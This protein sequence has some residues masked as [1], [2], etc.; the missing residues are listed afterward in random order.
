MRKHY[1]IVHLTNTPSF[2]KVNL[3]NEIAGHCSM[4]VV[5]TG[6]RSKTVNVD[7]DNNKCRFDFYFLN[8][9]ESDSRNKLSS[10]VRLFK[11]MHSISYDKIIFAGWLAPEY[12]I[13]SFFSP[14]HK[15]VVLS[16]SSILEVNISGLKGWIKRR[17]INRMSAALPSGK[18][19]SEL[20][21]RMKFSGP[22]YITGSVGIFCKNG[23]RPISNINNSARSEK[24]FICVARLVKVKNLELLIKV[25][26]ANGK[27]LTIVGKGPLEKHL[28]EMAAP[29][30]AFAGFI[31][32]DK[33]GQ[34]YR[35]HDIFILPSNYEPW[36]LVVEEAIYWGLPV[37]VS[38]RVGS[39]YEMVES[40]H[41]GEIFK[42][43]SPDS[44]Q[45][46][47]NKVEKD[48]AKYINAVNNVDFDARNQSQVNAYLNACNI[49]S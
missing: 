10:A 40:L 43:D 7:I 20:F 35:Q 11:L 24:K 34:I 18:P 12:N 19:H 5:F 32:N 28:K 14:R 38:D 26:N 4:L 15:N 36:G 25:F 27:P 37:I 49:K 39:A 46:A 3:C 42:Y 16:E 13:F 1:D 8:E 6:I 45:E 41:T 30:I 44:L 22:K 48:Y 17:I 9:G 33:L 23:S 2:Y 21:D 29:N 47:I 31:D